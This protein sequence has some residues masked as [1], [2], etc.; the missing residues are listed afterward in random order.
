MYCNHGDA[1][2]AALAEASY[3]DGECRFMGH[4]TVCYYGIN[5]EFGPIFRYEFGLS[6][7]D[8]NP[9]QGPLLL[10]HGPL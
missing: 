10:D 7:F 9:V 8:Q 1:P 2:E 5:G 6:L 4:V 3:T